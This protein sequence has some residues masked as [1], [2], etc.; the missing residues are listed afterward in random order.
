MTSINSELIIDPI[1]FRENISLLKNKL[2]DSSKFMAV[3]KSDAY[4][5]HL[6]N[7]VKDIQD[8]SDGFGV[9]RIDEAKK[10]RNLSNKK[11]LLM[12]GVYS[13]K[14]LNTSIENNFDL[15]V[16]NMNQFEIIKDAN[17]Y[18]GLWFKLNT[19]M[20]RLG[21]ETNEFLEI[22]EQYLHDKKFTLM[23]H[24]A[25]SNDTSSS[26]NESQFKIFEDI[27]SK[28]NNSIERSIAN[29]G[30]IMNYPNKTYDWVRCGIGIYG[31]YI[32]D[33]KLKTCL[34]YTS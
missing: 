16:H 31:G 20:N 11:I 10:I 17:H 4:G 21:F 18:E 14:D 23:T 13:K 29:T 8:L 24:L 19:G 15:V 2:N 22:Y 12:Q 26:S 9:V 27:S 5:H 28:L 34:L 7:I 1:I 30:C 6:E 32:G 25:S 33:D 3:I